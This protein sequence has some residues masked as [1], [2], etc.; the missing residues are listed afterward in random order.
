MKMAL[1]YEDGIGVLYNFVPRLR[2]IIL[3]HSVDPVQTVT[4]MV[5]QLQQ[6]IVY[7]SL[8]DSCR[9]KN[10]DVLN[11]C[12]LFDVISTCHELDL[13]GEA[14][15][16]NND[17]FVWSDKV[18]VAS[19][20]M[21]HAVHELRYQKQVTQG[22]IKLLTY[23][24]EIDVSMYLEGSTPCVEGAATS[25]RHGASYRIMLLINKSQIFVFNVFD[26][27]GASAYKMQLN[28]VL[29]F[30][31]F[32]KGERI[33]R[34]FRD[35]SVIY[36]H[37]EAKL[38]LA[39]ELLESDEYSTHRIKE[40]HL[41]IQWP[42][43]SILLER[44]LKHAQNNTCRMTARVVKSN[45]VRNGKEHRR[46]KKVITFDHGKGL[47]DKKKNRWNKKKRKKR[48]KDKYAAQKC[49]VPTVSSVWESKDRDSARHLS[50]LLFSLHNKVD[51][52]VLKQ[53]VQ[54]ST[55]NMWVCPAKFGKG[56]KSK[57]RRPQE[58]QNGPVA[59]A[60]G[61]AT[62]GLRKPIQVTDVADCR[63]E[64]D[65]VVT[66]TTSIFG[67]R[68]TAPPTTNL[69]SSVTSERTIR[70]RIDGLG[71]PREPVPFQPARHPEYSELRARQESFGD[72]WPEMTRHLTPRMA[73]YGFFATGNNC[74]SM[75][76]GP[77]FTKL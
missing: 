44:V 18:F 29:S 68:R 33:V 69:M 7:I 41:D 58:T 71:L 28:K 49:Y 24:V 74:C 3:I 14:T 37:V 25:N 12:D 51:I 21:K 60:T 48:S 56:K 13:S 50:D 6:S 36:L 42:V 62:G 30:Q 73:T 77:M 52:E 27:N 53:F 2:I 20:R 55:Q 67:Q 4:G 46:A 66:S 5:E 22:G 45:S 63:T 64:S 19:E 75:V 59:G 31:K 40:G 16:L 57:G 76:S 61:G 26:V 32:T 9:Y 10:A 65:S 15:I 35:H 1:P 23:E 17:L 54:P 38:Q 72:N 8:K 47:G 11:A 43:G 34:L 39:V 70:T